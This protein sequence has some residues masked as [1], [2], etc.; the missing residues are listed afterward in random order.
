MKK[1]ARMVSSLETMAHAD[2]YAQGFAIRPIEDIYTCADSGMRW[3][4]WLRKG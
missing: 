2:K 3:I 4:Y 1:C